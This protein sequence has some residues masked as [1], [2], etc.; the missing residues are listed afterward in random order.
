ML[1]L[2]A[3]G[4]GSRTAEPVPAET[5]WKFAFLWRIV[6]AWSAWCDAR[7]WNANARTLWPSM[8]RFMFEAQTTVKVSRR[9]VVAPSPFAG[10]PLEFNSGATWIS[11][12]ITFGRNRGSLDISSAAR[13][14]TWGNSKWKEREK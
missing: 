11:V 4:P 10:N 8:E 1:G 13:C 5:T 2:S 6:V 7:E 9:F 14:P 12:G 3:E